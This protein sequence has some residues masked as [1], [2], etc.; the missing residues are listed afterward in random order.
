MGCTSQLLDDFHSRKINWFPR[1][2]SAVYAQNELWKPTELSSI[3]KSISKSMYVRVYIWKELVLISATKKTHTIKKFIN[4]LNWYL[5]NL[6]LPQR[7]NLLLCLTSVCYHICSYSTHY[8]MIVNLRP[9]SLRVTHWCVFLMFTFYLNLL[10]NYIKLLHLF[11]DV[12]Q[13]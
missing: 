1:T 5:G 8:F 6:R 4:N 12:S 13:F 10:W 9:S 2:L 7:N 11:S 3:K